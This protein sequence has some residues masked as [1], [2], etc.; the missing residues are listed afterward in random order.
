MKSSIL[1]DIAE[2]S[3][4]NP[5]DFDPED[6]APDFEQSESDLEDDSDAGREHYVTVRFSLLSRSFLTVIVKVN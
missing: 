5:R 4:P 1:R 2:L 3:N 6:I